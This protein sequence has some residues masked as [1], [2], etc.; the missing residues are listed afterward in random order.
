MTGQVSG[1]FESTI[2]SALIVGIAVAISVVALMPNA[3]GEWGRGALIAYIAVAI[4]LIAGTASGSLG[5]W[6]LAISLAGVV[7]IAIGGPWG[8]LVS[9]FGAAALAAAQFSIGPLPLSSF[10]VP[11][12]AVLPIVVALRSLVF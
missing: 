10:L 1:L 8:L 11:A 6:A 3:P 9:G 2:L 5:I 7:A 12:L 4:A